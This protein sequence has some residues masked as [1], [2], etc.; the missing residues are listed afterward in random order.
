VLLSLLCSMAAVPDHGGTTNG[1]V[2]W[3]VP[4]TPVHEQL[5]TMMYYAPPRKSRSTRRN[6]LGPATTRR[7]LD[8][9]VFLGTLRR[10]EQ[11]R[12]RAVAAV[13][14]REA[15]NIHFGSKP[16]PPPPGQGSFLTGLP[17]AWTP[18]TKVVSGTVTPGGIVTDKHPEGTLPKFREDWKHKEIEL[19]THDR[20][21]HYEVVHH[22]HQSQLQWY[23]T[24]TTEKGEIKSS[25]FPDVF[26][27]IQAL[28]AEAKRHL[29][30]QE[31]MFFI[32]KKDWK[33]QMTDEDRIN[34]SWHARD[35]FFLYELAAVP[36]SLG[37][38]APQLNPQ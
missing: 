27:L 35:H 30:V 32:H 26:S 14:Q 17:N 20:F 12:L 6:P 2:S 1:F 34:V 10:K 23:A 18:E 16:P 33:N 8:K 37:P 5:P 13:A 29:G 7:P 22:G 25:N 19:E 3:C 36:S 28:N 31:P 9:G 38:W 11:E 15:E 21:V 4:R 24:F